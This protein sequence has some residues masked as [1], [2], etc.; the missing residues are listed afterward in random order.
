MDKKFWKAYF[1]MFICGLMWIFVFHNDDLLICKIIAYGLLYLGIL[2][3]T[4]IIIASM[5]LRLNK[6]K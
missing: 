5:I 4:T 2:L 1:I 6:R 3:A